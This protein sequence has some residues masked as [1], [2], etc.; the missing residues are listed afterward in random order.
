MTFELDPLPFP[1]G[2]FD[3]IYSIGVLD[4]TPDP[5][6]AFL[7]LA[8]LL[9]PGGRISVWVYPRE[10]PAVEAIMNFHRAISTRLPLSVLMGLSRMAAPEKRIIA[11]PGIL[12]SECVEASKHSDVP[13]PL[14]PMKK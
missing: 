7:G 9:K 13:S 11:F 6:G 5:R 14:L 3:H 10:R 2:S 4:H 1:P 8:A 12:K